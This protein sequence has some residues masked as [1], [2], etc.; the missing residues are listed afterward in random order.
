MGLHTKT[1]LIFGGDSAKPANHSIP[2]L[3]ASEF[4][5]KWFK[6]LSS[7]RLMPK[8]HNFSDLGELA[9]DAPSQKK[10]CNRQILHHPPSNAH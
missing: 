2:T 10:H 4:S 1:D 6:G 3:H 9:Q 7:R 5:V 8:D